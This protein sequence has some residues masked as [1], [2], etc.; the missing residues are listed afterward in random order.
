[1]SFLGFVPDEELP[2]LYSSSDAFLFL[3]RYEGFGL[4]FMESMAAGTPVIGTPVGGFPDLVTDGKEGVLVE[5]DPK[6]V[7]QAIDKLAD[8]LSFVEN[9][10]ETPVNSRRAERGQ[11][12]LGR[13]R[14]FIKNSSDKDV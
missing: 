10:S 14:P 5:R 8:D 6:D 11:T 12:L 2:A 3:S 9:M 13:L 4:T 1:M 7:A